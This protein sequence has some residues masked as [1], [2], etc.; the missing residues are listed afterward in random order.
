MSKI[1]ALPTWIKEQ[2]QSHDFGQ[3]EIVI[4]LRNGVPVH[5]SRA[6]VESI[7]LQETSCRGDRHEKKV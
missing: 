2:I 6:F 4:K 5:I 1:D 3:L 7:N